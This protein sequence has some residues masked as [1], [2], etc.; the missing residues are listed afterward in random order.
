[1]DEVLEPAWPAARRHEL[2]R[3]LYISFGRV[4]LFFLPVLTISL[5]LRFVF[6]LTLPWTFFA[7]TALL[8][9]VVGT[10]ELRERQHLRRK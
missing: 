6:G 5:V 10:P 4:G 1:V 9:F 8:V 7:F 2:A 3:L